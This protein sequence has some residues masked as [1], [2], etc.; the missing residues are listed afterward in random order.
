MFEYIDYG[1]LVAFIVLFI[2]IYA[3]R[4]KAKRYNN[5]TKLDTIIIS[6]IAMMIV[7]V[8]FEGYEIKNLNTKNIK[9]FKSE[10]ILH[11]IEKGSKYRV[12]IKNGWHIDENYFYKDSLMIRADRCKIKV[13]H[14]KEI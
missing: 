2:M 9:Y 3:L 11:C 13:N 7:Y 1:N 8:F 4:Q 5:N 14:K 12:S 6:A 10:E